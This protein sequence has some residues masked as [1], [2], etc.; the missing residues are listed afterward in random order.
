MEAPNIMIKESKKI[1]NKKDSSEKPNT[2]IRTYMVDWI[3][4]IFRLLK[5]FSL[6]TFFISVDIMDKFLFSIR[7]KQD[8]IRE[9]LYHLIGISSVLIAMKFE[10][11]VKLPI[12]QVIDKLAGGRFQRD[13]IFRVERKI[14]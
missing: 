14:L 1:F 4:S 6:K 10:E 8:K 2:V 12:P 5:D 13:K 9:N 7:N 3:L 11:G